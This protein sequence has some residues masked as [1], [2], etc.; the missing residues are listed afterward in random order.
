MTN[1]TWAKKFKCFAYLL[2]MPLIC[3]IEWYY[4]TSDNVVKYRTS[5]IVISVII[6][7]SD[8]LSKINTCK[9]YLKLLNL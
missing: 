4:D 2:A 7:I 3:V 5:L 1:F 8:V 6:F 9:I